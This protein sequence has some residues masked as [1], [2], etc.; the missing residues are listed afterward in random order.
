M[1]R[2]C[3]G[4][5]LLS[6]L[7]VSCSTTDLPASRSADEAAVREAMAGFMSALNDLDAERMASFFAE[8]MTAFVPLAQADRVDG[9]AAVTQIFR[10]FVARTK[11]TTPKLNLVPEDLDV[12]VSGNLGV[13]TFNIREKAP[14]ITRR[15]TFVYT[16]SGERWLISHFH[17]SDFVSP[18]K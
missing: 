11:P 8:Q 2:L 1:T 14:G 4:L 16:R 5:L 6:F 12:H 9:R 15:R 3:C 18:P 17:A 7:A 10:N 13:V